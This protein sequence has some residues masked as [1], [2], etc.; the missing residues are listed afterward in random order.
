[1]DSVKTSCKYALFSDMDSSNDGTSN[2]D[3]ASMELLIDLGRSLYKLMF[4]L[5]LLIESDHKIA[6]NVIQHLRMNDKMQ[7]LSKMYISVRGAI[8]RSIDEADMESLD[9]SIST[10]GE[11]TPTPSP[12]IPMNNTEFESMLVELIDHQKWSAA[13]NHVKQ[14][15][16]LISNNAVSC[17]T[18]AVGNLENASCIPKDEDTKSV[19]DLNIIMDIY[20]QQLIKDRSGM[21]CNM[22]YCLYV[23]GTF[24]PF[25]LQKFLSFLVLKQ[26]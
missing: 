5:L 17:F 14:H 26:N 2:V 4:Q 11:S 21:F 18:L 3:T 24:F 10:E 23:Y 16:Q 19:G 22:M 13:I 25:F 12:G 7:D 8:L 6:I 20:S 9:T 15:K 1:M